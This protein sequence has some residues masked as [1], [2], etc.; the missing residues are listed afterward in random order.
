VLLLR[1][2]IAGLDDRP[3]SQIS[4]ESLKRRKAFGCSRQYLCAGNLYQLELARKQTKTRIGTEL[5]AGF[6]WIGGVE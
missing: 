3:G 4:E 6:L 2:R 1:L 5:N